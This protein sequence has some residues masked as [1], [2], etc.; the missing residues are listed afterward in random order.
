MWK[1]WYDGHSSPTLVQKCLIIMPTLLQLSGLLSFFLHYQVSDVNWRIFYYPTFKRPAS[2]QNRSHRDLDVR[3]CVGVSSQQYSDHSPA[4]LILDTNR[5]QQLSRPEQC[6][7][8]KKVSLAAVKARLLARCYLL[9]FLLTCCLWRKRWRK[10]DKYWRLAVSRLQDCVLCQYF[11]G[12]RSV[13]FE[14]HC[15]GCNL[16]GAPF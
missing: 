12:Q 3:R 11:A 2:G 10:M 5:I 1:G 15:Y 16:S 6:F 13:L 8:K 4:G 9:G 14:A 7:R